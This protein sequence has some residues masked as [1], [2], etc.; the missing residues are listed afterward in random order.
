PCR[1]HQRPG[2]GG[3]LVG[4]LLPPDQDQQSLYL[5]DGGPMTWQKPGI[6]A[7]IGAALIL[8]TIGGVAVSLKPQAYSQMSGTQP[9]HGIQGPAGPTGATGPAG[10]TCYN[11]RSEERRVGKEGRSRC[12][13]SSDVCS[14]DLQA[15]SQM[16][17][18]QPSHGIQGP[19]GPTGATG[20]A[21][22]TCYNA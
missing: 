5:G 20:P 12:D 3:E 15:Y 10:I 2:R 8:L 4:G 7:A 1:H 16:S 6:P 13:W 21:G 19:A 11:A 18:T 22:I 17:G 9:S 14:S